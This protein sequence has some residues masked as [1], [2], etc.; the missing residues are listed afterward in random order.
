MTD[1]SP[2]AGNSAGLAIFSVTF[3]FYA[4][5]FLT[6]NKTVS[7]II[8]KLIRKQVSP[9]SLDFAAEKFTGIVF[10]GVVPVVLFIVI[11]GLNPA[12]T[13][14]TIGRSGHYWYL[15]IL[16]P[17]IAGFFSFL[18]SK[19]KG[20]QAISPQMRIR[21]WHTRHILLSFF[22]WTFY[23]FGYELFFRGI[24]WFLC[25][26]AFGFWPAIAINISIYSLVHLPK[27][28]F[29][30]MGAIPLGLLFCILSY[31]TGSFYPA[32]LIHATMSI[33]NELFS[34]YHNP[35]FKF[36]RKAYKN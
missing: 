19:S 12:D 29:M 25:F 35:E 27:G 22:C 17:A 18:S 1:L 4:Y 31:Y 32:F 5:H 6:E 26:N 24:L 16:L 3:L 34:I 14:F 11:P 15:L 28:T 30:T 23:L 36:F 7:N 9:E 10:L 21:N 13:G 8:I 2:E 20:N 33:T